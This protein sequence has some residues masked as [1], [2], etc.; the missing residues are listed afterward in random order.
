MGIIF[1]VGFLCGIWATY[2]I[3]KP[4]RI[5]QQPNEPLEKY[6]ER[7]GSPI[8][9][10]FPQYLERVGAIKPSYKAP[11]GLDPRYEYVSLVDQLKYEELQDKGQIR[12]MTEKEILDKFDI[13]IAKTCEQNEA[14]LNH[15]LDEY[16][17]HL[18]E[19]NNAA[20]DKRRFEPFSDHRFPL[21]KN[22][23]GGC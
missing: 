13:D 23:N 21:D 15:A 11:S 7:V 17:K 4:K 22:G 20:Q 18:R 2:Y 16:F 10:T 8:S 1:L 5:T 19:I 6:M 3:S 9:E 14:E 12:H